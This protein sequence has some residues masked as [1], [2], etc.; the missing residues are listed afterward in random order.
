MA[1]SI[2]CSNAIE[3]LGSAWKITEQLCRIVFAGDWP[4]IDHVDG[5]DKHYASEIGMLA[6]TSRGTDKLLIIRS[7]REIVQHAVAMK[8]LVELLVVANYPL[9]EAVIKYT[10]RILM[11]RSEHEETSGV[12]RESDEAAT[13]GARVETDLEYEADQRY[14]KTQL[15]STSA[16][17]YNR[18]AILI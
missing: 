15:E 1:K 10:H 11:E 8:F 14:K 9:D 13:H 2:Y 12:Y 16:T 17:A 6:A 3:N 7:R 18:A 5:H 4:S